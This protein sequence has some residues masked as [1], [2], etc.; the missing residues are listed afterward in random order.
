MRSRNSAWIIC[1]EIRW[2]SLRYFP[3][4]N[5][6]ESLGGRFGGNLGVKLVCKL[7]SNL[8]GNLGVNLGGNL[9]GSLGDN[10][11]DIN[12]IVDLSSYAPQFWHPY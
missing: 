10:R 5:Q 3:W 1:R 6:V 11:V 4:G 8:G 7:W 2:D 12:F 9:E